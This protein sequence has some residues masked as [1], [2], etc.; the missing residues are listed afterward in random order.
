MKENL[1]LVSILIPTYN[2]TEYL[3][4][5]L[6]SALN[7]TY[8]N[9]EIIICDDSTND[10]VE[11]MVTR[12]TANHKNIKYYNN[13]GPL[14]QRGI[15]NGQKCF[16]LS[17]G[18]Y[19]NFLFHDDVFHPNKIEIMVNYFM[20]NKDVTLVTSSRN[21]IN[22]NDELVY[23]HKFLPK[24][25]KI[26]GESLGALMLH[27]MENIVG[28]P[29]TALFKKADIEDDIFSY[30]GRGARSYVDMAIW[31]KLLLKG[32]A[33]Y[34]V[35]PLSSFRIHGTQNTNNPIIHLLGAI[36][37]YYFLTDSYLNKDF[38]KSKE[39]YLKI[40]RRWFNLYVG[41]IKE[42]QNYSPKNDKESKELIEI[43]EDLYFCY[44]Q[45]IKCLIAL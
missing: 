10:E 43:K 45:S 6:M 33:I 28:E 24:T 4:K 2:Q 27:I 5:A 44:S 38:I 29:T 3:E 18:E 7:Q 35:E 15:L 34:I 39:A 21:R 17:N 20:N 25:T 23:I 11:K 19:I 36:D 16:E 13:G 1:P 42:L 9:I 8:T 14:G 30:K 41:K 22:K 12:Y 31:F 32:N 40:L 26:T 37:K